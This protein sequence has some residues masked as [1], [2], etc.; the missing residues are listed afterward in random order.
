[1]SDNLPGNEHTS[2][3]VPPPPAG[4]PTGP[5]APVAPQA[6]AYAGAPV[7]PSKGLALTSLILGILSLIFVW[8]PVAG[9]LGGIIAL[10]LGILALRK[11]QSKGLSL[12]GIITGALATV[13][14]LFVTITFFV[15][16]SMGFSAVEQCAN[17]ASTVEVAGQTVSCSSVDSSY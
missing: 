17:G 13:I 9:A 2:N 15:A 8:V 3:P 12:T 10:I 7:A 14:G 4:G 16:L 11:R 6:P 1:M 5:G